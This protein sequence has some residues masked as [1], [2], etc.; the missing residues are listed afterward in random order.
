MHID[1]SDITPERL[2]SAMHEITNSQLSVRKTKLAT[3]I[4]TALLVESNTHILVDL[5]D[6]IL[7]DAPPCHGDFC[8][9]D[10][11]QLFVFSTII[12]IMLAEQNAD[13][14]QLEEMIG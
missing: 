5:I 2:C 1:P 12:G 4:M 13:L 7:D 11:A 10:K 3:K 14:K 9:C 6:S 8:F